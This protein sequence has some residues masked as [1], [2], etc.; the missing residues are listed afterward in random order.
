MNT[1]LIIGGTGSIGKSYAKHLLK[2]QNYSKILLFSRHEESHVALRRELEEELK[3]PELERV[4]FVIGNIT[5]SRSVQRAMRGVDDVVLTAALKHI[6]V[7]EENPDEAVMTNVIGVE[8][9]IS[10]CLECGVKKCVFLSTDKAVC[11]SSTY[12]A[13][14]LLGEKLV[15]DA[16][17]FGS[18]KFSVLRCGNVSGSSGSVIPYFKKLLTSGAKALPVTDAKMARFWLTT[19]DINFYLDELLKDMEGGEI[20]VPKM[21]SFYIKDLAHALSPEAMIKITGLRKGER[22]NE[23]ILNKNQ[24]IYEKENYFLETN[25]YLKKGKLFN[26]AKLL[27]EINY[28][29]INN[30]SWLSVEEIREKLKDI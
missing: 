13:T 25:K 23:E 3:K 27:N 15:L 4:K 11:P 22:I 5:D 29:T 8:N 17:K 28:S 18:T 20:L 21:P 24:D 9:V 6:D 2:E 30:N 12:G 26:N 7:C 14:K 19:K 16:N 10:S 1:I